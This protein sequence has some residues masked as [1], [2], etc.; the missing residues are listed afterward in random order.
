MEEARRHEIIRPM[1]T[2]MNQLMASPFVWSHQ[3]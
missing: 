3:N 2:T 1:L